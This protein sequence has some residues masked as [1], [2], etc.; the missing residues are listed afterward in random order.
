MALEGLAQEAVY[1]GKEARQGLP[2]ARRRRDQGV[3]AGRDRFPAAPLDE[4]RDSDALG[5]PRL[6]GWLEGGLGH[7]QA[8]G[9]EAGRRKE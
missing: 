7:A 2:R 4:S 6:D 9:S 5:K 8:G 1:R 3:A